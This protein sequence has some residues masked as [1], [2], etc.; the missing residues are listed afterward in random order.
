MNLV[1][2]GKDLGTTSP[3]VSLWGE[4]ERLRERLGETGRER[5]RGRERERGTERESERERASKRLL[6]PLPDAVSPVA[7]A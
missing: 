5:A 2:E 7:A 6:K 1:V 4:S 3:L